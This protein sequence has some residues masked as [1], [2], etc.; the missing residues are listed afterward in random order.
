MEG[1]DRNELEAFMAWKSQQD[2]LDKLHR[3]R[4]LNKV[5]RKGEVLF[6]GSSLM[7]QFPVAELLMDLGVDMVIYNRGIGGYTT[8]EFEDSLDTVAFDL[9]PSHIFINIGTNDLN[10]EFYEEQDLI[11]RYRRIRMKIRERLPE[12]KIYIMAYYP[13]NPEVLGRIPFLW[14]MFHHRT[15]R[16]VMSANKALRELAEEIDAVYL[17]LGH[18]ISDS[19]GRLMEEYTVDGIHIYGDG[20]KRILEAMMPILHEI[21]DEKDRNK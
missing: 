3:Y 1:F 7:E 2:K 12:T 15:N 19:E 6:C 8:Y 9:E 13:M 11:A 10:E 14:E 17:D 5:A 4:H 18:A 16:R 21:K 20:Y